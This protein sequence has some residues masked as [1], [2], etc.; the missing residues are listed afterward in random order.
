MKKVIISVA[1]LF[2]STT[3]NAQWFVAGGVGFSMSDTDGEFVRDYVDEDDFISITNYKNIGFSVAPKMGYSLNEKLVLGLSVYV[4]CT[5]KINRQNNTQENL[6]DWGVY[7]FVRYTAFAYK[8]F[9]FLLEGSTGVGTQHRFGKSNG[10]KQDLAFGYDRLQITVFNVVPVLNYKLTDH[11]Q[12]ETG[13]NFLSV[14]YTISKAKNYNSADEKV[15]SFEHNLNA[16]FSS[17]ILQVGQL[18]L[19]V[20]YTF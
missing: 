1:I 17:S 9:S 16:G 12:I 10:V 6:I 18:S 7:P 4:N 2:I 20:V 11:F 3:L 8:N 15:D 13:L 5:F 14:G 19:G